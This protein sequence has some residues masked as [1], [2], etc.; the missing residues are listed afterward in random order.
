MA[1]GAT[2]QLRDFP[3]FKNWSEVYALQCFRCGAQMLN[4][5]E[6]T[7]PNGGPAFPPGQGEHRSRCGSCGMFTYFDVEKGNQT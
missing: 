2:P 7:G 3:M 5:Q 6:R 4:L 1:R